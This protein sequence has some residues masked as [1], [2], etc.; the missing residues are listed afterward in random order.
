MMDDFEP[1]IGRRQLPVEIQA[2]RALAADEF[3]KRERELQPRIDAHIVVY[4]SAVERLVG[5]H[6]SIADRTDLVISSDTR[7]SA[8]W[9]LSGRCLT[10]CRLLLHALRGGFTLEASSNV[11]AM[12]EAM[13]LLAAVAFED[14]TARRWLT[15]DD[16]RPRKARAVMAKKQQLARQRMKAAGVEPEGVAVSTGE[17]IY[18]HFSDSAHHRRGPITRSISLERREFFYGPHPDPARRARE[19]ADI[20]QLIETTLM[21]VAD[22]LADVVGREGLAEVLLQQASEFDR[23]REQQPLTSELS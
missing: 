13:D 2:L 10:E 15:G 14:A 12:V 20:G 9:E 1:P 8:I 17:W 6:R 18:R 23:V 5:A 21:I 16:V 22:S 11:R 3:R 4:A 19:V 7:W